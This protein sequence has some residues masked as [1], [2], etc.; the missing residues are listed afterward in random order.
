[1]EGM[2]SALALT[3]AMSVRLAAGRHDAE[4]ALYCSSAKAM[5]DLEFV[6]G[7]LRVIRFE[8]CGNSKKKWLHP[9]VLQRGSESEVVFVFKGTH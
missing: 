6:E 9:A 2:A 4:A 3:A 1:M 7:I 5:E 8:E